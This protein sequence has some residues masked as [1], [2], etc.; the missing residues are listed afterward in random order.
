MKIPVLCL[1]RGM[2]LMSGRS[3][4][5][6]QNV[7]KGERSDFIAIKMWS[8]GER[9]RAVSTTHSGCMINPSPMAM[10]DRVCNSHCVVT[11]TT[12][13]DDDVDDGVGKSTKRSPETAKLYPPPQSGRVRPP[14]ISMTAAAPINLR[15]PHMQS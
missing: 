13:G 1:P 15:L 12:V 14:S 9:Q 7:F 5:S 10:S 2:T 4:S 11:P 6:G 8:Q 3:K